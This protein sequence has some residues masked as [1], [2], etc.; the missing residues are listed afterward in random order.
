MK[1][2]I[3]TL[4][5]GLILLAAAGCGG[6]DDPATAVDDAAL[7][8]ISR[9]EAGPNL[10]VPEAP[11]PKRLVIKELKT[12]KGKPA[13]VGDE[14]VVNYVGKLW[15]GQSYSNSWVYD[16][17]PSFNL[18][19]GQLIVGFEKGILGMKAGGRRLLYVPRRLDTFPGVPLTPGS[20]PLAF[21]ADMVE[22]RPPG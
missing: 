10:V 12:G 3:A 16:G 2:F 13:R 11:P 14:V 17:P 20:G 1:G 4:I 18:G 15:T 7:D 8:R 22:V 6:S 5:T 19:E 21:L 9:E